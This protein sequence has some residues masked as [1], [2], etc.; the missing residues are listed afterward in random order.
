[1][2]VGRLVCDEWLQMGRTLNGETPDKIRWP[3]DENL[4]FHKLVCFIFP[5]GYSSKDYID[6]LLSHPLAGI[7]MYLPNETLWC[8]MRSY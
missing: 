6:A 1:M 5:S 3:R 4:V 2:W 7:C 8:L